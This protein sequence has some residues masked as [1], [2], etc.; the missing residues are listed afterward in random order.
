[1]PQQHDRVAVIGDADLVARL[2][3]RLLHQRLRRAE[4]PAG[5]SSHDAQPVHEA[6]LLVGVLAA[7]QRMPLD[8]RR[9]RVAVL[10]DRDLL[11]EAGLPL[12]VGGG[13]R[14]GRAP[15]PARVTE[16]CV[17]RLEPVPTDGHPGTARPRGHGDA[18]VQLELVAEREPGPARA[19]EA[20]VPDVYGARDLTRGA[21]H[22]H[23]LRISGH[24]ARRRLAERGR[25]GRRRDEQ[26][27]ADAAA[28]RVN[29]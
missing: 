5:R 1:M 29:A 23:A 27:R 28:D 18:G 24:D 9:R 15:C 22:L 7:R 20:Q 4:G 16:R 6:L 11:A 3:A 2:L 10:G 8:P 25:R 17:G 14:G 21:R 12:L 26:R 13:D 19:Q